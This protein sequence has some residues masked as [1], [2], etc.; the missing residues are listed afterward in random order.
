MKRIHSLAVTVAWL[1][2]ATAV[3][4]FA[5]AQDEPSSEPNVVV[6]T[7]VATVDGQPIYGRD[8]DRMLAKVIGTRQLNPAMRPLLR[9]QVLAEVV[10]RRL[11]LAYARRMQSGASRAEIDAALAAMESK[12]AAQERSLAE[13]LKQ[14]SMTAVDLRRQ[15]NWELTWKKY[16]GRYI[17]EKRLATYFDAHRREFDGTQLEVSHILLRPPPDAGPEAMDALVEKAREIRR[18]ITSGEIS[19]AEASR[20]H[21]AGPSGQSGGRLGLISRRGAM[22]ESFAQAAFAL[23]VGDVSQP[24]TTRFGVHL[25]RCDRIVP[26]SKQPAEVR[27]PLEEA[28]ARELLDR[29]ARVQRQYTPEEFTGKAPYFKPGTRELVVP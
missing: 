14:R 27:K 3:A 24:V 5:R 15:L 10:D 8:V 9:A 13:V 20:K 7:V 28:L 6:A 16:L 17:T 22:V 25:I 19:F 4:G 21:S 23:E 1:G 2:I 12:L 18:A 11:V 26:G 29:L